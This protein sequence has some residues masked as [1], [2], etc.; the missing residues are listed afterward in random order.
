MASVGPEV[1]DLKKSA[2]KGI[3]RLLLHLQ[4][5][6]NIEAQ[7]DGHTAFAVNVVFHVLVLFTALTLLFK[8]VVSP[9]EVDALQG[10]VNNLISQNL[11][12]VLATGNTTS[13]N[14]LKPLLKSLEP[15]LQVL[16]ATYDG[17]SDAVRIQNQWVFGAAYFMIGI[18]VAVLLTMLLTLRT[19]CRGNTTKLMVSG[20]PPGILL[21]NLLIFAVIG[22]AEY[23]F[24]SLV[25]SKY[26]PVMPSEILTDVI[27]YTK[28]E[29]QNQA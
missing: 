22:G 15:E 4:Q 27:S 29:F 23:G 28:Q 12:G 17:S 2:A 21:E 10:N 1:E 24:F 19:S 9:T 7:I 16:A 20:W 5:K 26:V 6:L 25:A 8:F 11:S 18:L 14:V 13:G 3:N